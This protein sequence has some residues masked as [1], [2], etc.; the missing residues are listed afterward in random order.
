MIPDTGNPGFDQV[1]ARLATM[2]VPYIAEHTTVSTADIES[3]LEAELEFWLAHPHGVKLY[4]S[5]DD[6][7]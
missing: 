6:G 7:A 2:L 4:T 5:E 1:I 3:V